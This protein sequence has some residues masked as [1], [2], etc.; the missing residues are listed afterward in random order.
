[1]FKLDATSAAAIIASEDALHTLRSHPIEDVL[2]SVDD[3]ESIDD[4]QEAFSALMQA[5][6]ELRPKGFV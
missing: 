6:F 4:E 2:A 1:M 5:M 3:L